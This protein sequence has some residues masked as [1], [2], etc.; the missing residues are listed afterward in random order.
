MLSEQNTRILKVSLLI[1]ILALGA[2]LNFQG[3][4]QRGLTSY[5]E[6]IYCLEG[7]WI[8]TAS[9]AAWSAFLHKA[10]ET[11]SRQNLYT[12]EEEAQRIK[13]EIKGRPPTWARPLF[14]LATAIC[15]AI[16]GLQANT[17]ILTSAFFSTV[18][19]FAIFL[20]ARAMFQTWTA[21]LAA[22]LL[23]ICGYHHVYSVMGL[24][25]NTAMCFSLFAFFFFY[26][27]C[28]GE[29]NL[30]HLPMIL[31]A[32]L[33]CGLSF[34]AHD[35]FL[36][37]LLVMLTCLGLDFV[38]NKDSRRLALSKGFLLCLAFL[39]PLLIFEL[40][41]YLGMLFLR[42]H[43]ELLPFATYFEELLFRHLPILLTGSLALSFM[44]LASQYPE[45]QEAGSHLYNFFTYPYLFFRLDGPVLC[46]LLILGVITSFRK[47]SPADILLLLW[48]FI[49]FV[50]FSTGLV[51]SS[52]YAM[53]FLPAVLIL[54]A[55]A[56]LMLTDW[57]QTFSGTIKMPQI[58]IAGFLVAII[59]ASN[60]YATAELHAQR[61]SYDAPM[62]FF[63]KHGAKHISLQ[64]PASRAYLG[65]PE[66]KDP[67]YS[68]EQLDEY[69]QQGY[70]Y[71]LI[72]YHKY[73]LNS[74]FDKTGRGE[75]VNFIEETLSPVFTYVH[76]CYSSLA[77][78]FEPN[79]FFWLTLK[80][81]HEVTERGIDQILIYDLSQ[82]YHDK[83]GSP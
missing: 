78:V 20:L 50:L 33:F 15:T 42:R 11:L 9:S 35:R 12:F 63:R 31:L 32:G 14:S 54:A 81:M 8:Y 46:G 27:T 36:Y 29:R 76:P 39:I 34:A 13:D 56:V 62:E 52:R 57:T 37:S 79:I 45:F 16:V 72:D 83:D 41:Y 68:M 47:R 48:L 82:L 6:G 74:P 3:I 64:A 60:V 51:T 69:Y 80:T 22:F 43:G 1:A 66:V 25:D 73:G 4:N 49:P 77:Y 18:S 23:A 53:I 75:V 19:I 71:Y 17:P 30:L 2:F 55:R 5:D 28:T 10:E 7:R 44:D 21:L 24:A 38:R 70:R 61:C 67:P 26:K 65:V 40:P 59:I 58:L